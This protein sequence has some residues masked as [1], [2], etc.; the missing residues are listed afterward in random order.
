MEK[1]CNWI[2]EN[3]LWKLVPQESLALVSEAQL[4]MLKTVL[5]QNKTKHYT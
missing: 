3:L 5:K 4:N 2:Q 1:P